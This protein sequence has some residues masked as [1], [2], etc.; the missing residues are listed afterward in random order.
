MAQRFRQ[1]DSV[2]S[3]SDAA[4]RKQVTPPI[5]RGAEPSANMEEQ[6]VIS[7]ALG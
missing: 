3:H 6:E 2:T 4:H 5:Q 7:G 1:E